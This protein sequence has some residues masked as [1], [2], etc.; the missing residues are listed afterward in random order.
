MKSLKVQQLLPTLLGA[1]I[2]MSAGT[3]ANA[4]HSAAAFNTEVETTITGTVKEYSFRNPHVYMTLEV[5]KEDGS[6]VTTE[7]EAGA[8]SV[9]SPLGFTRDAVKVGDVVAVHGNPGRRTPDEL[10]LGRGRFKADGNYY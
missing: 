9:L 10:L 1:A 6:T 4:H 7:V 8:G 5:K 2:A 3:A